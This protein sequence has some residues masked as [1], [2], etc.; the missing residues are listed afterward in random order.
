MSATSLTTISER[1]ADA[2]DALVF[3]A[4]VHTVYNPL[5][6]AWA[7]HEMY[8]R[9]Y[10][11]GPREVVL[12]GMNPGPFGMV[13]TGVPF[14]DATLAREWLGID[15]PV[16]RP[17]REHP[18]RPILGFATPR[19]EV[20]GSRLW[21]WAR[22]T[23]GTPQRFFA[24]FFVANYCP[25]AFVE[26]SG[27]NRTPDKL[28]AA[29]REALYAACDEALRGLVAA[30]G[31]RFVVGVG[32]FAEERAREALPGF[33]GVIGSVLH[34]SPAN[35]RANRGW[36]TQATAELAALGIAP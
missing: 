10:G 29:E 17:A 34:P 3:A 26:E 35:P 15:A 21:S 14:G 13:Q 11:Q 12:L 28:P 7:P 9:L 16:E 18:K 5:R 2:V 6:Y 24:R 8:L 25:L 23:H 30:L 33:P 31:P 20:S 22:E 19:S 1:L 27:R 4:P 36:A 32:K